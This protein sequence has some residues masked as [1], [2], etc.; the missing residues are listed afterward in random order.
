MQKSDVPSPT[1][2]TCC[3]QTAVISRWI[4]RR[5]VAPFDEEKGGFNEPTDQTALYLGRCSEVDKDQPFT[6]NN[7]RYRTK[8]NARKIR[9]SKL[10]AT[11]RAQNSA[12]TKIELIERG[13]KGICTITQALF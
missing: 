7:E 6:D 12:S 1:R 8:A 13:E 10:C 11:L 3:G 5:V 9:R 4:R 2:S